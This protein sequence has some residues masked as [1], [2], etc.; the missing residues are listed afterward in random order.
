MWCWISSEHSCHQLYLFILL[1]VPLSQFQLFASIYL[2]KILNLKY[3]ICIYSYYQSK[4]VKMFYFFIDISF[5]FILSQAKTK[6]KTAKIAPA[7]TVT[8][9]LNIELNRRSNDAKI[10]NMLSIFIF[11]ISLLLIVYLFKLHIYYNKTNYIL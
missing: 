11:K 8:I 2:I 3:H 4:R 10:N 7:M 1:E 6:P 9:E 5:F